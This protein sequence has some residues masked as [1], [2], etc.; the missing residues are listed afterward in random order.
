MEREKEAA[1]VWGKIDA[2]PAVFVLDPNI[3][4]V[5]PQTPEAFREGRL[6]TRQAAKLLS[7]R[8]KSADAEL[9]LENDP[10]KGWRLVQ[11]P[12]EDTDQMAVSNFISYLKNL[13]GRNFPP[14]APVDYGFDKPAISIHCEFN[15][16][17]PSDILVGAP[18]PDAGQFYA[19]QDNGIATILTDLEVSAMKRTAADFQK[20]MLMEFKKDD[21]QKVA[22]TLDGNEYLFEKVRGHWTVVKPEGVTLPPP[23][24]WTR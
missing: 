24:T 13:A 15:G 17:E 14:G 19:R 21:A 23:K 16:E 10:E 20:K 11:P 3:F 1:C 6:F 18:V 12:V 5:L 22:L 7:L 4:V 8:Y 2:K 9:L